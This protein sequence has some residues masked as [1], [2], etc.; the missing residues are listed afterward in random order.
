MDSRW[1]YST[2]DCIQILIDEINLKKAKNQIKSAVSLNNIFGQLT[3]QIIVIVHKLCNK[4]I[5]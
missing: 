4:Q 3:F 1:V 2:S 5:I